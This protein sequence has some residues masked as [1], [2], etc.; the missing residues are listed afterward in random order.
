MNHAKFTIGFSHAPADGG[1]GSFQIRLTKALQ[2]R[3]YKIIFPQTHEIPDLILVIGGTAKLKWLWDCRRKGTKIV[4]RLDGINWRHRVY[5]TSLRYYCMSEV[6]NLLISGIR[7]YLA[8]YVVYQ[9]QFVQEWWYQKYGPAS[10]KESVIYNGV[11]LSRFNAANKDYSSEKPILLCVEGN[12][13]DD[14]VTLNTLITISE[15]LS[16]D[17]CI[18]ET[19]VCGGI[20]PLAQSKLEGTPGLRLLGK[21]PRE[22]MQK[23]FAKDAIFLVLETNPPCPNSVIEALAAGIPV[24]GFDTGS[25]RE[26]VSPEAGKVVPPGSNPWKMVMPDVDALEKAIRAI[27][28]QRKKYALTARSSAEKRFNL[29]RVT[30]LYIEVF[31]QVL[32]DSN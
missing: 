5:P 27:L 32:S 22:C 13:Q 10:S 17:Q 15:R 28:P 20:S 9:S 11:D 18:Q 12:V 25:L 23:I 1:P 26:L 30:D 6:R 8:D 16:K 21:V 19:V 3:G 24:V 31:D 4:Q 2:N 14:A 7:K 29:E